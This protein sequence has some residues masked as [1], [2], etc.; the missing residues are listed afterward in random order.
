MELEQN[1]KYLLFSLSK[2]ADLTIKINRKSKTPLWD[3]L[4]LSWESDGVDERFLYPYK[5]NLPGCTP[6]ECPQ[7]GLMKDDEILKIIIWRLCHIQNKRAIKLGN[8][9]SRSY[10]SLIIGTNNSRTNI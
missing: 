6:E 7:I 2:L 9:L 1:A 8:Q 5:I 3:T 10:K 4:S